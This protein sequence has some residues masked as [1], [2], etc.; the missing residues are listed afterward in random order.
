[1]E[2]DQLKFLDEIQDD[3]TNALGDLKVEDG[4]MVT[5]EILDEVTQVMSTWKL[6]L[7]ARTAMIAFDA[8]ES[9]ARDLQDYVNADLTQDCINVRGMIH[10]MREDG[11]MR[12]DESDINKLTSVVCAWRRYVLNPE[13][14][15]D[16]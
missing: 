9:A 5:S 16:D 1:M 11:K 10:S 12:F 13:G 6:Q 2:N 15:K 14:N 4:G 8:F 3:V 7:L